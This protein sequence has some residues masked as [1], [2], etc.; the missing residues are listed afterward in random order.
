MVQ[1]TKGEIRR[2]KNAREADHINRDWNW[3]INPGQAQIAE[4]EENGER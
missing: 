3:G 4:D 2:E 1:Q